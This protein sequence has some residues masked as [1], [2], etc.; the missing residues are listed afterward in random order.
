MLLSEGEWEEVEQIEQAGNY[1]C[2][3]ACYLETYKK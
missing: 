3:L 2:I 1:N